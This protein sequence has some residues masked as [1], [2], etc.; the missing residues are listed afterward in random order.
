MNHA[1]QKVPETTPLKFSRTDRLLL[2]VCAAQ[3][4]PSLDCEMCVPCC[5]LGALN[6]YWLVTG[7]LLS[8]LNVLPMS[9]DCTQAMPSWLGVEHECNPLEAFL[10]LA[11]CLG[12][13]G[14]GLSC[15]AVAVL[16]KLIEVPAPVNK[17]AMLAI[18]A[19]SLPIVIAYIY[20]SFTMK[21]EA[22]GATANLAGSL[23]T[24][25]AIF[26]GCFVVALV[27]HREPTTGDKALF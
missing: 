5:G 24:F 11:W 22:E 9:T 21:V 3:L 7:L 4:F 14:W 27:A 15:A 18:S 10:N 2:A 6:V 16:P 1:K 19:A 20:I 17:A 26:F 12:V 25:M 23:G 13:V 8:L